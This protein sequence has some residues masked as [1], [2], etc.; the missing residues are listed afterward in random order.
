VPLLL[1]DLDDTLIDRKAAF[2]SWVRSFARRH[3]LEDGAVDRLV[4][5]DLDGRESR[6]RFF[7]WV[8]ERWR[9]P[10]TADRLLAEYD[11]S[12]PGRF[13]PVD[14]EAV[15]ALTDLRAAGWKVGVVTN[16]SRRQRRK[17]EA[18]GAIGLLDG[19][20][21]SD[22]VGVR[23][24]DP[25]IFALAAR[26]CGAPLRG[27][28]MVGDSAEADVAGG[29]AAGLHTAW[30]SHGR[31]WERGDLAPDLAVGTFVEAVSDLAKVSRTPH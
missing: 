14:A 28:W 18:T 13:P 31:A 9:L 17:M 3:R 2:A 16:G 30:V 19:W 15:A 24:P 12:L 20:C 6:E 26:R 7:S 23:K 8:L 21:I 29:C 1:V 22:E 4:G 25:A 27:G 10:V 11:E 5:H